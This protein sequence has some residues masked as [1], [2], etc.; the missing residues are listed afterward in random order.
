[1]NHLA[2]VTI[3]NALMMKY[4]PKLVSHTGEDAAQKFVK[5]LEKDII[6]ISNMPAKKMIFGKKKKNDLTKKLN[7]GYVTENSLMMLKIIRLEIIAI[8]LVD[9]EELL[10][11]HAFS[12]IE[13]LVLHLWCFITLVAMIATYL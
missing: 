8:I 4:E 7:V 2:F 10:I 1:M 12:C 5:M 3:S 13:N 6:E 9:I 11:K